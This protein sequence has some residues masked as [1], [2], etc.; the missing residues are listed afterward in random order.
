MTRAYKNRCRRGFTAVEF[1]VVAGLTTMLAVLLSSVWSGIGR[2]MVDALASA[3][4]AQE[5]NLAAAALRDFGG[6]WADGVA[7][8]GAVGDYQWVGRMEPDGTMLRMC[9]DGPAA[10]GAPQWGPPDFVVSYSVT[11]G[12]LIRWE[13]NTGTTFVVAQYVQQM[14]LSDLGY[15]VEIQLTFS[16]RNVNRTYTFVGLDP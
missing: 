8:T 5:A 10:D 12:K 16:H 14:Q 1:L 13:E 4:V 7:R 15:G 6:S 3:Q 9:Y 2:P 11:N